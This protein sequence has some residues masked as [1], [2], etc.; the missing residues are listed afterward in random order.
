MECSYVQDINFLCIVQGLLVVL[1]M[2]GMIVLICFLVGLVIKLVGVLYDGMWCMI[3][4]DLIVCLLVSSDDELG[5]LVCGFNQ[6]VGYLQL[7]Y[8]M[9]EEWVVVEICNLVQCNYEL[10]VFYEVILLFSEFVQVEVFC[11][12]FF[13]CIKLVLGVDVGVVWLYMLDF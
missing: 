8:G 3:S 12:G 6:M 13:D 7:V 5:G 11:Q 10:G 9:L 4:N 2:I 1:V